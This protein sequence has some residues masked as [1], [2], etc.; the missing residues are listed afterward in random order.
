M[1]KEFLILTEFDKFGRKI[2][3]ICRLNF[4]KY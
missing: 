1:F 2:R 4:Q 3:Q